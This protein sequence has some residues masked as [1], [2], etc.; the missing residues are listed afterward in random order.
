MKILIGCDDAALE[1][2][3]TLVKYLAER[4]HEA[5][6]V[7]VEPGEA[8]DYPE[9]AKRLALQITE[10]RTERGILLCGTGIGMAI[11]A[12]KVPGIRAACCHD[13]YSA[14]RA[15]KSNDAQIITMGARVIGP[16][17]AKSLL[18][19]WLESEFSGGGSTRKV[20]Q[21]SAIERQYLVK[22]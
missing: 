6:D 7:G 15:R 21:I 2:K 20:E 11:A 8:V 10:G 16:E 19:V 22:P 1:L 14:E 5:I 3:A 18:G 12:N 17:L 9:I 4:G 13:M